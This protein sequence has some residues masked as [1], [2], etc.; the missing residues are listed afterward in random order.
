MAMVAGRPVPSQCRHRAAPSG[1]LGTVA[2]LDSIRLCSRLTSALWHSSGAGRHG[3]P[4]GA[5]LGLASA[6]SSGGVLA[7]AR[8][9]RRDGGETER[10]GEAPDVESDRR[11]G[12]L[13]IER[14]DFLRDALRQQGCHLLLALRR[15]RDALLRGRVDASRSRSPETAQ[16]SLPTFDADWLDG[17]STRWDTTPGFRVVRVYIA[18]SGSGLLRKHSMRLGGACE[19]SERGVGSPRWPWLPARLVLGH[20]TRH[21]TTR[22]AMDPFC[23]TKTAIAPALSILTIR[24]QPHCVLLFRCGDHDAPWTDL[25]PSVAA[26]RELA[27]LDERFFLDVFSQQPKPKPAKKR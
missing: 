13:Q 4:G 17:I 16:D 19:R 11:G 21:E 15:S 3:S 6:I 22:A 7:E 26:D 12:N 18:S 1:E 23:T 25:Y 10:R 5:F 14:D 8:Y 20:R 27:R 24:C 9:Q 2:A